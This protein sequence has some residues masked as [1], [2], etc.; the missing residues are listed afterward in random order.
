MYHSITIGD[1]NTWDDWHLIPESRPLFSAPPVKTNYIDIPGGDGSLD[2]STAMTGKPLYNNRT[3]SW[4]FIAENG[5]KDWTALYSEI[6]VYL[7][8]K[9]FKAILEDDPAY[10]YEG[11]FWVNQWASDK[12][13]SRITINYN[14][15]PYKNFVVGSDNWKWDEF[16]FETGIIRY[17]KNLVVSGTL[18]VM[19]VGDIMDMTPTIISTVTGMRVT[20]EGTTYTL[21][22]GANTFS[23]LVLHEGENTL[24]FT[25]NGK[26]TINATGGRL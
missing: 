25:G 16:N 12:D 24:R 7:Q 4:S 22:R 13:W 21:T 20:F 1:K 18:D 9:K 6:M 2:L 11:R 5:F 17:Y 15:G 19:I 3:G 10:Y 26:I 8:G 23:G 14:V